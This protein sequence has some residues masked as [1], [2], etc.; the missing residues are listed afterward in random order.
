MKQDGIINSVDSKNG[1]YPLHIAAQNGHKEVVELLVK[2]GAKVNAQNGTGTT[3]LHMAL[4]YDY[5]FISKFLMENGADGSIKNEDGNTAESGIGGERTIN[6]FVAA[7]TSAH[8]LEELEFALEKLAAQKD[9]PIDKAALVQGGM[10]KKRSAKDIWSKD[11]QAKF[12]KLVQS[13]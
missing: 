2:N 1:N 11:I 5:W 12:M 9:P 7:L 10:A 4:E 3:P 13:L 8:N 6:D